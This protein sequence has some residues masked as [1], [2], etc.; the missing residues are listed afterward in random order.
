M[1]NFHDPAKATRDF[2]A[3]AHEHEARGLID[4]LTVALV[5]LWHTVDGLYM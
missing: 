5:K 4:L 2:C 3:L 1:A